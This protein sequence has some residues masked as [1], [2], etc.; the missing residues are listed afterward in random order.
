[1]RERSASRPSPSSGGRCSSRSEYTPWQPRLQPFCVLA[2]V[3]CGLSEQYL[4][5]HGE[6]QLPNET[7]GER[8][9]TQMPAPRDTGFDTNLGN[10]K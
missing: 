8:E 10:M 2:D 6:K 4:C 5:T 3:W 7:G 1:M 9:P